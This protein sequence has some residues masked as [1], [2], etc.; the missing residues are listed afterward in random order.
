MKGNEMEYLL[1]DIKQQPSRLNLVTM[2]RLT[3]Y[4]LDDGTVWEMTCDS[5]Y[6]NFKRQGWEQTVT[7]PNPF[8]TYLDLKRTDR[9]TKEGIGVVSAD[10]KSR[11]GDRLLNQDQA[12]DIMEFDMDKRNRKTNFGDLFSA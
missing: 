5:S 8:A 12:V 11:V 9:V 2:W 6:K 10:S 7:D 4:C 3:F 1:V